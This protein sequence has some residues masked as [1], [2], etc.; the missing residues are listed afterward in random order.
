M[1][2]G[3]TRACKKTH[4]FSPIC[5]LFFPPTSQPTM[6][7]AI[8][9]VAGLLAVSSVSGRELTGMKGEGA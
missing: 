4:F 7:F 3:R 2:S 6:K 5:S 1:I 9:A 8:A